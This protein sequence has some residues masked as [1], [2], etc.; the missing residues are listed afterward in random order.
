VRGGVL[1]VVGTDLADEVTVNKVGSSVYRVH[2]N[3]L[4]DGADR[5]CGKAQKGLRSRTLLMARIDV[6]LHERHRVTTDVT[7]ARIQSGDCSCAL[8]RHSL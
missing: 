8:L 6:V 2:A 4:P 3:F 5:E 1:E 7:N